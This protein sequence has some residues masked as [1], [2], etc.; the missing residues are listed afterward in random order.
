MG[1]LKVAMLV[2]SVRPA[3]RNQTLARAIAKL[4]AGRLDCQVLRIDDL[5][6]FDQ[7]VERTPPPQVLRLKAEVRAADAILFITPEYNRSIPGLL[8][9][10]I[11]WGSRPYGD[12]AWNGKPCAVAGATSGKLGTM[13]AQQHLRNILSCQDMV[14][15]GQPEFYFQ[16]TDE[17]IDAQGNADPATA[18]F[19]NTFLERFEKWIRRHAPKA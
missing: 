1:T 16:H 18:K 19:I 13:A 10:A 2:G 17:L 14:I 11:D 5:P 4:A 9:N 7:D 12:S 8:K 6:F 3:S 15:M